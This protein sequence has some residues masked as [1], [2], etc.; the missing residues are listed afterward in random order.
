MTGLSLDVKKD[1]FRPQDDDEESLGPE[2]PY[3]RVSLV[4]LFVKVYDE[5]AEFSK[6]A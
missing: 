3:L 5:K 2:V 1:L 4:Q 6:S